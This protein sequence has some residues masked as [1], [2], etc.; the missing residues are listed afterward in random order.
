MPQTRND[1]TLKFSNPEIIQM[2]NFLPQFRAVLDSYSHQLI[3]LKFRATGRY[4]IGFIFSLR[5]RCRKI[6]HRYCSQSSNTLHHC[7]PIC[8]CGLIN[9]ESCLRWRSWSTRPESYTVWH[10]PTMLS[11]AGL[12]Q[13]FHAAHAIR[14]ACSPYS[15]YELES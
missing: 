12:R 10:L 5:K 13:M 15:D 7:Y 3:W 1:F 4:R 2:L 11:S 9:S 8:I 14:Q 6:G